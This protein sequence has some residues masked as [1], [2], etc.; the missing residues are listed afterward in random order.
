VATCGTALGV[1]HLRAL[2][3]F[4]NRL[5]LAFDSDEAGARAAERAFAFHQQFPVDLLVLILPAGQDPADFVLANGEG[6]GQ[7]FEQLVAGAVP[8]VEYMIVRFFSGHELDDH[9]ARARGIRTALERYVVPLE[10]EGRRGE[11]AAIVADRAGEKFDLVIEQLERMVR[12]QGGA[13]DVAPGR[14]TLSRRSPQERVE[15]EALKI[16][17]QSLPQRTRRLASLPDDRF[18]GAKARKALELLRTEPQDAEAAA[19]VSAAEARS[20]ALGRDVA[21]LAM[22][23]IE[24]GDR[25][26]DEFAEAVFLRLEEFDLKRRADE[27]RKT[28]ERINPEK[29]RA[30]H[31]TLFEQLVK[32]EADR[33]R[34]REAAEAIGTDI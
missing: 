29:H 14:P 16:L 12:Q 19:L 11:H 28:L 8:L 15:R 17:V 2:S 31:E 21:G 22:E 25:S 23:P 7:V 1:E 33:R 4:A 18:T 27:V 9:E 30:E 24:C 10:D 13:A 34:V 3:K 5:V 26:L 20:D 6:A 32:L